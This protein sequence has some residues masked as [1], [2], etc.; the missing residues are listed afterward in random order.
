MPHRA[1][2][3]LPSLLAACLLLVVLPATSAPA[4]DFDLGKLKE[5][6]YVLLLR[7]VKT[8]GSDADDLDLA[9]CR[10]QRQVAASGRRQ[11]EALATRFRAAGVTAARLLASQWCR[12]R[13]TAE[14][15]GLG[16][17]T[18]EPALNYPHWKF[19][20]EEAMNES[21]RRFVAALVAPAPGAP[22]VLVGHSNAF[23]VMGLEVPKSGG[24]LVLKLNGTA[25]PEVV[26][27]I[28]APE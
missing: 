23:N 20:G 14:L 26:G 18:D 3:H 15:L 8:S 4:A 19:G 17:P 22:L 1:P 5:G 27:M 7:H 28:S 25:A 13:E 2:L 11:A 24:G 9:D 10:T 12:A 16:P 6:G 21:L